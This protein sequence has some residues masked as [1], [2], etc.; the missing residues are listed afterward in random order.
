MILS[1]S[2]LFAGSW[3][4]YLSQGKITPAPLLPVQ[5][6]GSGMVSFIVGNTASDPIDLVTG[7]ELEVI[8]TFSKG[9]PGHENPI[10]ALSGSWLQYF[11]W[12]YNPFTNSFTGIQNQM[13]PAGPVRGN[14]TVLYKVTEN[15]T[16]MNDVGNGFKAEI[17]APQYMNG[18]NAAADDMVS[19]YTMTQNSPLSVNDQEETL[20]LQI[21]SYE[22]VIYVK[23]LNGKELEGKM[24]V[25]NLIGQKIAT[26]KL[27]G[28]TLNKFR[29][30]V[31]EGYY[32]AEVFRNNTFQY[33][34][35]FL[36]K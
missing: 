5:S 19:S 10:E 35:V 2:A 22:N 8:I 15:T 32:F 12:S 14:I 34:K 3:N 20:K 28:G 7:Q 30:M 23:D 6:N 18:I 4:P 29:M 13:I 9:I 11:N 27:Y 26:K 33:E 36:T 24:V 21:W 16:T 17:V 25:Y 1:V 31:E